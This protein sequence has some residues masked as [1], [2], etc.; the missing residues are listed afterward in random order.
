VQR[1]RFGSTQ[2]KI[3]VP[4]AAET[5]SVA[6][7]RE[8]RHTAAAKTSLAVIQKKTIYQVARRFT[9]AAFDA[10]HMFQAVCGMEITELLEL[11]YYHENYHQIR[12]HKNTTPGRKND[13]EHFVAYSGHNKTKRTY[14]RAT[15]SYS[16]DPALQRLFRLARTENI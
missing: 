2:Y 1:S 11:E 7:T 13:A 15:K 3:L 12:G 9:L 14:H 4:F 5:A 16:Y 6:A 10:K 8:T